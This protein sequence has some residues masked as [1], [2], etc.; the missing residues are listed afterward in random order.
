MGKPLWKTIE[1]EKAKEKV[2]NT[3]SKSKFELNNYILKEVAKFLKDVKM[4]S[5]FEE[6]EENIGYKYDKKEDKVSFGVSYEELEVLKAIK[7]GDIDKLKELNNEGI[8]FGAYLEV[9]V[10][11][12]IKYG[13]LDIID[14]LIE[15]R[16][17]NRDLNNSL[18][19]VADENLLKKMYSNGYFNK[20]NLSSNK[21]SELR[22]FYESLSI[23]D[24]SEILRKS[25]SDCEYFTNKKLEGISINDILCN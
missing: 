9:N 7:K 21:S 20:K 22:E 2:R 5:N 12:A 13:H 16:Q 25:H 15:S 1:I 3:L 8:Y 6:L 14:Y 23:L 11:L 19:L 24:L 17:I 18:A 4:C 10:R